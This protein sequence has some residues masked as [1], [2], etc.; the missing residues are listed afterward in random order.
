LARQLPP[1]HDGRRIVSISMTVK[2]KPSLFVVLY[3]LAF[4]PCV[5]LVAQQTNNSEVSP[6]KIEVTVKRVL[7]PVV[8]RDAQRRAVGNLRKEDFHVF[9]KGK[10][11]V[12]SGFAV[13]KRGLVESD[14]ESTGPVPD[15]PNATLQASTPSQRFI[16]FLFDDMHLGA[17]ELGRF[18]KLGTK[19]LAA[20]LTGADMAA[21]VSIS[22]ENSG[23]TRD[24]AKLE[25]AIIN[26]K[27]R[28]LYQLQGHQC[29]DIDYYEADLIVNKRNG[30]A[31]EAAIQQTLA[32]ASL[33]PRTW[34]KMAEDMV[35]ST[36]TNSLMTGDQDVRAMLATLR[37]YV[38]KMGTLP[39]QRTL[40][41]VSPGFLTLTPEAMTEKARI[42]DLAAQENVTISALD[43]RG[44]YT[45]ELGAGARGAGSAMAMQTGYEAQSLRASMALNEDVMAELADGSGGTYFHNN[46]DL[47]AGFKQLATA[48]EYVYV[49]EVSLDNE[50]PDGTYHRLKVKVDRDGL[51]VQARRGYFSRKPEESKAERQGLE[52]DRAE[53]SEPEKD[54]LGKKK[55]NLITGAI[56]SPPPNP[57]SSVTPVTKGSDNKLSN[58]SL[59]WTPPLV[60][61]PVRSGV[62]STPCVLSDILQQASARA[63]ELYTSLQSFSAQERIE[64]EA[65][66]HMGY[67][68]DARTGNF[69]YVVIFQQ[70]PG[71]TTVQ[72]SR[73]PKRG[74]RLLTA[75]TQDIGLPEMAL[76][77]LPEL[78]DDYEM[79]CEGAA[80]WSGRRTLVVH[81]VA[82]KDKPGRT[83]SFRDSKGKMYP[84]RLK[85]RAWI[86][87]DSGEVMHMET[88]LVE[89][90]PGTKVRHWYMSISYAP[91]EFHAQN[92]RMLL[93]QTVDA[94]CDF[95]DHRTIVY[96]TFTDFMLFS[97]DTRQAAEK[98]KDQ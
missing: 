37:E 70:T 16:V 4:T 72:E 25:E 82:R 28:A 20:S 11:K 83:L 47:E 35:R 3:C 64:Y 36:A 66:D 27:S 86:A 90:I 87:A 98:P 48:P 80:E 45:T 69:D 17:D 9:D 19:I 89:Q 81:F 79:S 6:F 43:A 54:T 21:V 85:G 53:V 31:L 74:S 65:S 1:R 51:Q 32:C 49:L 75:F 68:R 78:Q 22:G 76:M 44:L 60:D 5:Y 30:T 61:E 46:N 88:S 71:G 34:H 8:V 73:R 15:D 58:R 92:V 13:E 52:I 26:L 95:E 50:N 7:V 38:R 77:F 62:S 96:H 24:R 12:I 57:A 23:L 56:S 59:N 39:G 93:P 40:I 18:Q 33:D 67:L 91:V 42:L 55:A 29:S 41:L 97:V 2:R 84:A 14:I 10:P 63:G 94:Y